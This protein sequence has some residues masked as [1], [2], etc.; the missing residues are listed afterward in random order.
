MSGINTAGIAQP[1]DYLVGR[2]SVFFAPLNADGSP[3][4]YR[5]LGNSPGLKSN[6]DLAKLEHQSSI[7]GL[8][9]T[10]KSVVLSQTANIS[11][12]LDEMNWDNFA[13]YFSGTASAGVSAENSTIAG[14]TD[15][16]QYATALTETLPL[17]KTYEIRNASGVRAYDLPAT[18]T[19]KIGVTTITV[20]TDYTYDR[21]LGLLFVKNS[22]GNITAAAADADLKVT[23]AATAGAKLMDVVRGLRQTPVAGALKFAGQNAA[24]SDREYEIQVHKIALKA[25]GDLNLIS[26]EFTKLT[27]EGTVESNAA[28]S[29]N[30]PYV[31]ITGHPSL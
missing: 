8:K 14:F 26:D 23:V 30:S 16:V 18:I 4:P 31:T 20:T 12:D 17:N 6:I 1:N 7:S 3:G 19:V 24:D 5:F 10:D 22:A 21:K 9:V 13:L 25:S 28:W 15:V 11:L 29:P 2:G 27:L